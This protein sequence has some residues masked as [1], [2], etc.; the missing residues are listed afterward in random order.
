M[1][2]VAPNPCTSARATGHKAGVFPQMRR[3]SLGLYQRSERSKGYYSTPAALRS[4][5]MLKNEEINKMHAQI[6]SLRATGINL[7]KVIHYS[8]PCGKLGNCHHKCPEAI[9]GLKAKYES[10]KQY[11]S[12]TRSALDAVFQPRPD[13]WD[14]LWYL[15]EEE[16]FETFL[17]RH[18]KAAFKD[19][20][21]FTRRWAEIDSDIVDRLGTTFGEEEWKVLTAGKA[22]QNGQRLNHIINVLGFL[23]IMIAGFLDSY[24]FMLSR[25]GA[26]DCKV[27]QSNKTS[28]VAMA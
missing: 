7:A 19:Q 15:G 8:P 22:W 14:F 17:S 4:K 5:T 24:G 28:G 20:A 9:A 27:G 18:A 13:R 26:G 10:M 3:G 2:A 6:L 16:P 1:K 12:Y 11:L 21:E 23:E 25:R